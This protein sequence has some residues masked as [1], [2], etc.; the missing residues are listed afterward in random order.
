MSD[1]FKKIHTERWTVRDF[2]VFPLLISFFLLLAGDVVGQLVTYPIAEILMRD[3]PL[4]PMLFLYLSFI[5]IWIVTLLFLWLN[6]RD[7]P[8]LNTLWTKPKGNNVK[9]LLIGILFGF[10]ANGA[11]VLAA[12]LNKDIVLSFSSFNLLILLVMFAAIFIQ[13]SAEELVERCFVYQRIRRGYKGYWFAIILNALVFAAMH[14][15]NDGVTFLAM[16]EIFFTGVLFSLFVRY[17]DSVWLPF[18]FHTMWNYTQNIIFGLPNSGYVSSYSIFV[19]DASNARESFAYHPVFGIESTVLSVVIMI[20]LCAAVWYF[21]SRRKKA[22]YDPWIDEETQ[23]GKET[24]PAEKA[25][26]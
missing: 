24:A 14:L 9:Y 26:A 12:W 15:G 19:L 6:E 21:G 16:L 11:S 17:Y 18:G 7:R 2:F 23:K 25:A 13:A 4:A 1:F 20:V 22:P 5:G 8:I 3:N 10:L